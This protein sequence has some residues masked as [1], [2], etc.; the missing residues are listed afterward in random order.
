METITNYNELIDCIRTNNLTVDQAIEL[1]SI[2]YKLWIT[3][4]YKNIDDLLIDLD[5][6]H[7][8]W[9]DCKNETPLFLNDDYSIEDF[10]SN[11]DTRTNY[12][13]RHF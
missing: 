8:T 13:K 7:N 6:H 1:V 9:K 2:S 3:K 4:D 11:D 12:P 5:K 10:Y